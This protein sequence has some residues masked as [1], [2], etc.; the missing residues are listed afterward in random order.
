MLACA[1]LSPRRAACSLHKPLCRSYSTVAKA[2]AP[3]SEPARPAPR[4]RLKSLASLE[5]AAHR[6]A[7]RSLPYAAPP[8][9]VAPSSSHLTHHAA[10]YFSL[11][12]FPSIP[13]SATKPL[14]GERQRPQAKTESVHPV[15]FLRG[16]TAWLP[17]SPPSSSA[18]DDSPS[19]TTDPFLAPSALR[20]SLAR[21]A[22]STRAKPYTLD[23]T[24]FASKKRVHKSAVVRERCKRRVREAIRLVV[25]RGARAAREGEEAEADGEGLVRREEDVRETGPRKWL[26]PGH[27]YIMSITLE[28]YRAPLPVLVEQLR[29]A[30]RSLKRKAEAA[31]LAR[32]LAD[33]ELCPRVQQDDRRRRDEDEVS[34]Q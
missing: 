2:A 34:L 18:S 33:L 1:A 14:F 21:A 9:L 8:H 24:L 5:P 4:P 7:F 20:A 23:L 3:A 27:H 28:V 12:C 31:V 30:L 22:R 15:G 19:S 13:R 25:V 10:P 32:Q 11:R 16:R 17:S 29:T 6:L 26:V